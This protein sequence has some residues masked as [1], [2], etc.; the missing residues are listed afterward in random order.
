MINQAKKDL[1]R[2]D[3]VNMKAARRTRHDDPVQ[4][5]RRPLRIERFLVVACKH[6]GKYRQID[7]NGKRRRNDEA[8]ENLN[9]RSLIQ[10]VAIGDKRKI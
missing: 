7:Q 10:V 5:Q 9:G 8:V 1:C 2:Y 4:T 6:E 3:S